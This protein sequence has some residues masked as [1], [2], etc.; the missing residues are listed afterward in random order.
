MDYKS[1]HLA[2]L[3]KRPQFIP[4]NH[5]MFSGEPYFDLMEFTYRHTSCN[6][7]H[8]YEFWRADM[9][10]EKAIEEEMKKLM[11]NVYKNDPASSIFVTIGF[12]HQTW[13][14]PGCVKVIEK[15][16]SFDWIQTVRAVFELHRENG[17]HPHVHMLITLS[18][19]VDPKNRT[20]S[21]VIEKIWAAAGIKNVCLK[22]SFIDFKVAA[23]YHHKYIL[24]EKQENKMKY[25]LEDIKWREKNDIPQFFEKQ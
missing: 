15:I 16:C 18:S 8:A 6:Q 5:Y 25:V 9:L 21:K 2:W 22:K 1:L 10:W 14:I 20:K 7:D 13:S 24:G 19:H 3:K 12:N 4:K 11:K 17:L 23:D